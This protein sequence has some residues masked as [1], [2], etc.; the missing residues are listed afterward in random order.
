MLRNATLSGLQVILL[1]DCGFAAIS[2]HVGPDAGWSTSRSGV[3]SIP[4]ANAELD[5]AVARAIATKGS[6]EAGEAAR[7]GERCGRRKTREGR[8]IS[9]GRGY[10][11]RGSR[12]KVTSGQSER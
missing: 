3:G 5:T 6:H 9:N 1:P 11:P 4:A 12:V 7:E 2:W 10:V 8:R